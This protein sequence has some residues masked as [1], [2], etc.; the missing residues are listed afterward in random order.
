MPALE[1]SLQLALLSPPTSP[2]SSETRKPRRRPGSSGHDSVRPSAPR[3]ATIALQPELPL[4][5]R[6]FPV[7]ESVRA[8]IE[9]R[10]RHT[11]GGA[12]SL[13]MTDNRR[14]M[15]SI[16]RREGIRH[17]RLHHMFSDA[18]AAL[19]EAIGKY[20]ARGDRFASKLID[21]YIA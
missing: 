11:I 21:R 13:T 10:L 5:I 8:A 15:L 20:L 1:S 16:R 6:P 2:I 9:Q 17:V 3:T 18:P 12:V 4:R 14:T 7:H 19:I